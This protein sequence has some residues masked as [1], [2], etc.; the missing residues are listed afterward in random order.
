MFWI[1]S[2]RVPEVDGSPLGVHGDAPFG[3]TMTTY[4]F[5]LRSGGLR[6]AVIVLFISAH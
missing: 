3:G 2:N 4:I 5:S 6:A 1:I